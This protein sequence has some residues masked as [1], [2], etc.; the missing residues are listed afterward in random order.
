M[1]VYKWRGLA[2]RYDKLAITYRAA[3]VLSAC[4]TWSRL[5]GDM[6]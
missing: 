5:L 2:A 4:I 1:F 3:T 6:P